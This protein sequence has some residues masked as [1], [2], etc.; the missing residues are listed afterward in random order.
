VAEMKSPVICLA[1]G[2]AQLLAV[3]ASP[4]IEQRFGELRTHPQELYAFL[5]RMPKGADL[6]N[7]VTGAVYAE[8]YL[9]A[10]AEDG[11]CVDLKTYAIVASPCGE[12]RVDAS[13]A[14]ADNS[15]ASKVI[16]SLS[17]RN[18]VPGGESAHDHFF[19]TFG[20]F[21][22]I[23]P[24]HRGEFIAEIVRRAAQQ[25]ES[26]LELMAI[27]GTAANGIA[28][29]IGTLDDFDRAREK[30]MA[31]GLPAV[32]SQMHARVDEM[33]RGLR[34]ALACEAQPESSACHVVV[35]FLFEVLR[36]SP[37]ER[38]F[39]QVLAGFMLASDDPHIV[40]VNF[41]QPEDGV[42]SMRDYHAQMKIVE[43]ARRLYPKVHVSLHA[44]E[45]AP[46][47]VPPEG[48]R[49]H[50]REAVEIAQAERIGHGVDVM[51]ET[52]AQALLELMKRKRI[53]V[54]INLT[55]NDLILGVRGRDHPLLV[56]RKYGVPVALS[57][58]DE[59]VARGHLTEEYLRA[60]VIYGLTYANLKEM[61]RNSLEYSFLPGASYWKDSSYRF[62]A[63]P[64]AAGAHSQSCQE[65]IES[66]EKAKLQLDLET[67]FEVFERSLQ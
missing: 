63:P 30:L 33:E 22:P 20:K 31:A 5:L 7:H 11:L 40:G 4:T 43:Y 9:R 35:R 51:Y 54:E 29:Q 47:L 46:G 15:L 53:L 44:G 55:S 21:G 57:T 59:G 1:A 25:N 10:A 37:K 16:D 50:I 61:A 28:A 41:V 67:R 23:K 34:A 45:L 32:V 49:F 27:N 19:A 17:M 39:A 48:L 2:L 60:V 26:Y 62:P 38:I 8:S 14:Q 56:Y 13:R 3:G 52:D 42:I 6:H 12:G 58:D 18:F 66:S 64:C 24:T 36:E 65:F